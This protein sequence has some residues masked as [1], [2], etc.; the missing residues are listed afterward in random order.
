VAGDGDAGAAGT[1]L[2]WHRRLPPSVAMAV[3]EL[4]AKADTPRD[5]VRE[6]AARNKGGALSGFEV[7]CSSLE[8]GSRSAP[9]NDT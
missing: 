3:T 5:A 4:A 8:S 1:V 7:S 2:R 9:C 6:M